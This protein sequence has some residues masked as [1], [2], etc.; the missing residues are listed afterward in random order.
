MGIIRLVDDGA[1]ATGAVYDKA[2]KQITV[3]YDA[4]VTSAAAL[5]AALEAQIGADWTI[6]YR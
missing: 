5:K 3:Y 6:K 1:T 2:G 4:T